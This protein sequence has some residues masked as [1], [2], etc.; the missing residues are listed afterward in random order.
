MSAIMKE[1]SMV[2]RYW[3]AV[4]M[5]S[6]LVAWLGFVVFLGGIYMLARWI[7]LCIVR[8]ILVVCSSVFCGFILL[9]ILRGV[10]FRSCEM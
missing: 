2:V 10:K 1:F 6:S 8:W 7:V 3:N 4:V 5:S 9:G